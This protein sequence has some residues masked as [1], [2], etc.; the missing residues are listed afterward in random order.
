MH[1]YEVC[2]VSTA[3]RHITRAPQQLRSSAL[4]NHVTV[5]IF[6]MQEAS[7]GH[8]YAIVMMCRLTHLVHLDTISDRHHYTLPNW[9]MDKPQCLKRQ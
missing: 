6:A 2:A 1:E 5:D 4:F 9:L 7:N 8:K 3:R